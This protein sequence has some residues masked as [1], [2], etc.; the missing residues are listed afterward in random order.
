MENPKV[1]FLQTEVTR[2]LSFQG[3]STLRM[4]S[5]LV[6]GKT[7]TDKR[8]RREEKGKRTHR[9]AAQLTRTRPWVKRVFGKALKRSRAQNF[10][11]RKHSDPRKA[12]M[13]IRTPLSGSNNF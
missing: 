5:Q 7:C 9:E 8:A 11:S 12:L 4:F 1:V 6:K 13:T 2:I 3:N 10:Y